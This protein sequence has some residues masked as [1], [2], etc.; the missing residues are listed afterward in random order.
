MMVKTQN[1]AQNIWQQINDMQSKLHI[2]VD[3]QITTNTL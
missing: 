2:K 1:A 3:L